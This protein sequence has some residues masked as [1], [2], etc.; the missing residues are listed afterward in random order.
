MARSSLT[1]DYD[2]RSTSDLFQVY[3]KIIMNMFK[4][5]IMNKVDIMFLLMLIIMLFE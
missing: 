3:S 5:T 2:T 4:N 1:G